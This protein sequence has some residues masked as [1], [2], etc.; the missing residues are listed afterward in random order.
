MNLYSTLANSSKRL[1][2]WGFPKKGQ[3]PK[4]TTGGHIIISPLEWP[5]GASKVKTLWGLK[6]HIF[7]QKAK[8]FQQIY[9]CSPRNG[10]RTEPEWHICK[11]NR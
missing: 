10:K 3:S 4:E 5:Y 1:G 2:L 7:C 9:L 6:S 8:C 11:F